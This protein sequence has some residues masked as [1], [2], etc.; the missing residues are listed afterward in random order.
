ML[1]CCFLFFFSSRRRH[2]RCALVT[3]V[4]TCALPIFIGAIANRLGI[5]IFPSVIGL[6]T[7]SILMFV[8]FSIIIGSPVNIHG[9]CSLITIHKG[10]GKDVGTNHC[11]SGSAV[12]T[13]ND[14]GNEYNAVETVPKHV[15]QDG[16]SRSLQTYTSGSRRTN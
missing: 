5:L 10:M 16:Q 11:R 3:G 15:R 2:T 1:C 13:A 6:K 4:Q 12:P 14:G 9:V 7:A 8:L